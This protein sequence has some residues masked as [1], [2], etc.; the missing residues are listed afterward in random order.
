MKMK[1]MLNTVTFILE[2]SIVNVNLVIR[3]CF[4]K[5][6]NIFSCN[7]NISL[8]TNILKAKLFIFPRNPSFRYMISVFSS[9][10]DKNFLLFSRNWRSTSGHS[11]AAVLGVV[12]PRRA[13]R[14]GGGV[15][16]HQLESGSQSQARVEAPR[17]LESV[18][19]RLSPGFGS[20][21]HLGGLRSG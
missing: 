10:N 1:N 20:P 21:S 17:S 5:K 6:R 3:F 12:G 15:S 14:A 19:R 9:R 8:G 7:I 11:R 4:L 16:H 2:N 18:G 13:A